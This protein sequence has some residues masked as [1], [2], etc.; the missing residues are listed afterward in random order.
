[1]RYIPPPTWPPPS[2][3]PPPVDNWVA[4]SGW[5]PKFQGL[6]I[7]PEGDGYYLAGPLPGERISRSEPTVEEL[8]DLHQRRVTKMLGMWARDV[9][10]AAHSYYQSAVK[11]AWTDWA[12][13]RMEDWSPSQQ[14]LAVSLEEVWVRGYYLVMAVSQMEQWLG[15][16][17]RLGSPA[18]AGGDEAE[19]MAHDE[20]VKTLRNAV[21]HLSDARFAEVMAKSDPANTRWKNPSIDRLPG[22]GLFLGFTPGDQ[23]FVF[24]LVDLRVVYEKARK[25]SCVDVPPED[26]DFEPSDI[27][28]ENMLYYDDES[29]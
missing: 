11:A 16:Y 1:M 4:P 10:R 26:V 15:A 8:N 21:E 22:G 12:I 28:Y 17:R 14:D 6:H 27:D 23:D 18:S 7:A 5:Q 13:E 20:L 19:H 2:N 24:G 25:Y 9:L 3:W 29:E